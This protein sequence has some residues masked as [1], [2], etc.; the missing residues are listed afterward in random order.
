MWYFC[1]VI[2]LEWRSSPFAAIASFSRLCTVVAQVEWTAHYPLPIAAVSLIAGL[3]EEAVRRTL[4][5]AL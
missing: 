4:P 3:L 2:T 1:V 5:V